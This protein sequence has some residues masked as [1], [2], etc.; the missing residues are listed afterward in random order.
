MQNAHAK[1]LAKTGNEALDLITEFN[2]TFD[3]CE[4]NDGIS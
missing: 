3:S 4:N 2:E 1:H